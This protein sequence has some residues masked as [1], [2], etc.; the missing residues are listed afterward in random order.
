MFLGVKVVPT[1]QGTLLSQ[2]RYIMD[3]LARTCKTDAKLVLT[4]IPTSPS[5]MLSSGS[6]LSDPTEYRY[7]VG[8]LQNLLITRPDI[9][10]AVNK[11][12]QFMHRP[13]DEHWTFVK[14]PLCY[15]CGTLNDGLLLHH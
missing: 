5:L 13:T 4:L 6:S 15:L 2:R 14:H 7:V 11:L 8:S 10:I 9:A 1:E 3:L 12:S